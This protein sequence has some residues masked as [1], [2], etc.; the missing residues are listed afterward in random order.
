MERVEDILSPITD[1]SLPDKVSRE[2]ARKAGRFGHSKPTAENSVLLLIDHQVGLMSSIRDMPPSELKRNV[3]GLA[4]AAKAVEMPVMLTTS[5]AQWQNGD[6]IP[7]LKEMFPDVPIIRRT[8]IINAYEDPTFRA[9][10]DKLMEETGRTHVILA[11]VTIGTCTQFPVLSLANDGYE[12]F[13]V[14]DAAGAWNKYEVDAAVARMVQAG[15]QPVTTFSLACELQ[16]DWKKP[17]ADAMFAPFKEQMPEY[18]WVIQ[19]FW[20]NYGQKVVPDPFAE[21]QE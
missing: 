17:S 8:G 12:V 20:D 18:G 21:A 15:A 13:P 1:S 10:F 16:E 5:L 6:L 9:A 11:G 7:E 14:I 2:D 4:L 3:L 19:N